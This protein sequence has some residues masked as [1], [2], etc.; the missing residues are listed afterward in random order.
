MSAPTTLIRRIALLGAAVM[1]M[2]PAAAQ[3]AGTSDDVLVGV[4]RGADSVDGDRVAPR[5]E[6]VDGSEAQRL[7]DQ[8]GVRFVEPDGTFKASATASTVPSDR[9][10]TQQWALASAD[11]IGAPGA[12][13]TSRG[14][15]AVIAV[16]DTGIDLSHPDLAA[17]LW[18][19]PREVPGNGVD[20][21]GN[22]YADDVHGANVLSG[23]GSVQ[24]GFGHGTAMSGGAA[25]A[26]NTIGVTGVAPDAKIMPVKVLGDDGSGNTSSVITGIRYAIAQGAD[27]I[28]LSM[29]GPDRSLALEE[30]LAAAKAAGIVVVAS[31]GNDGAD[32]DATPSYPASVPGL[33]LPVAAQSQDGG[34]ASFSAYG[35][36]VPLSAPGQDVLSTAKGGNYSASSGTSI[37]TAQVSGA[38]ALLAA[39]RPTAT[40]DQIRDALVG[41]VRHMRLDAQMVGSGGSLDASRSMGRLIPGA[42]PRVTLASRRLIRSKTGRVALKWRARGAVGAVAQYR[43]QVGR[44]SFAVR[45]SRVVKMSA[46]RRT[47]RL[48]AGRHRFKVA[49]Y[50]ASGRPLATRAGTVK[51]SKRK[52]PKARKK[53][54]GKSK[55]R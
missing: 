30:T 5:V 55:R 42:G 3:A 20:D 7:E 36:S 4:T 40:P 32:R 37:A 27:V 38:A 26:A 49:A 45:S 11:G 21:D 50:D 8:P 13:W 18:T 41:G 47:L 28:N 25:A 17:N 10:F 52:P 15:G 51:V 16:V 35:R 39:A 44:R 29:N 46:Q 43:V 31:A 53:S 24:D 9:L 54:R 34:L 23:N 33:T 1:A 6:L 48:K 12:W 14:A 22:G 2:T 19:N